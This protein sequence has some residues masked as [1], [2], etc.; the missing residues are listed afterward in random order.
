M[1]DDAGGEE[2]GLLQQQAIL[3]DEQTGAQGVTLL[4]LFQEQSSSERVR[5]IMGTLRPGM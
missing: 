3:G 2:L 4:A 1:G 5:G